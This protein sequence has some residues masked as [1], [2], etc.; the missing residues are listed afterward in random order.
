MTFALADT[1]KESDAVERAAWFACLNGSQQ[2]LVR[3]TV[4]K[5]QFLAGEF[6][7]HAGEPAN[8]WIGVTCGLVHMSVTA[9]DGNETTLHFVREGEW[10][11]EG[12]LLKREPRRYDV[13]ATQASRVCLLPVSTFEILLAQN[14]RFNHFL[15]SNLNERMGVITALLEAARLLDPEIRVARC[16]ALLTAGNTSASVTLAQH[17]LASLCGLSR[18]RTNIALQ[19]LRAK[20]IVRTEG[21]SIHIGPHHTTGSGQR[22]SGPRDESGH[23]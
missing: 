15:L 20:G 10:G 12:S 14:V 4:L 6:L 1:S 19:A 7:A 21:H 16:L 17:Q 9:A 3:A 18:Q 23:A 8:H 13:I 5:R 11:G 22:L 2:A